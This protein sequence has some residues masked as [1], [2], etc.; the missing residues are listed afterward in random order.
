MFGG[1]QDLTALSNLLSESSDAADARG[2]GAG[3]GAGG[4]G[5]KPFS[6]ADMVASAPGSAAALAKGAANAS[7]RDVTKKAPKDPKAIW[8]DDEVPDEEDIVDDPYDTRKRPRYDISYK[9]SVSAEDVFL[10]MGD[11]SPASEDCEAMVVKVHF[12]GCKLSELELNVTQQ[13]FVAESRELKL[14]TFLP[15]PVK[16]KQGDAKWD[17]AK[18]VLS[19][20]LP[21]DRD[22]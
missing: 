8:D 7:D 3:A 18:S 20:T 4:G 22:A 21:I 9:Q 14:S 10:G 1:G 5:A 6:P 12:P 19:V 16:H 15:L 13:K 17:A 11:K 2:G